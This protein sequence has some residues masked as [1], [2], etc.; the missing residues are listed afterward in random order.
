MNSIQSGDWQ[1]VARGLHCFLADLVS[2]RSSAPALFINWVRSKGSDL[3]AWAP[4][5]Q[6]SRSSFIYI[7]L[8]R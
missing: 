5:V 7:Q 4:Q 6:S 3:G 2:S 1:R 8:S